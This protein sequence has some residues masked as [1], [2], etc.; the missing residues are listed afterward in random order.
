MGGPS[1]QQGG[2]EESPN[3]GGFVDAVRELSRFTTN[4]PKDASVRELLDEL[5]QEYLGK[6]NGDLA[7]F[8]RY[9]QLQRSLG[10]GTP[11]S[12]FRPATNSPVRENIHLEHAPTPQVSPTRLEVG[13]QPF[14][15][16]EEL[17]R[18]DSRTVMID[19][20]QDLSQRFDEL[21]NLVFKLHS[22]AGGDLSRPNNTSVSS[23]TR[24]TGQDRYS[25]FDVKEGPGTRLIEDEKLRALL[26]DV[27]KLKERNAE[28]VQMLKEYRQGEEKYKEEINYLQKTLKKE[29]DEHQKLERSHEKLVEKATQIHDYYTQLAKDFKKLDDKLKT[30]L[31]EKAELLKIAAAYQRNGASRY[32]PPQATQPNVGQMMAGVDKE[33]LTRSATALASIYVGHQVADHFL[34]NNGP[35]EPVGAGLVLA[36]C[37]YWILGRKKQR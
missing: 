22:E 2:R 37:V 36:A 15:S 24:S 8:D 1:Q 9:D 30:T 35:Y 7:L 13:R 34:P 21:S 17:A 4:T 32:A 27:K 20:I 26:L 3:S 5:E 25:S 28:L 14:P 12:A 10:V 33:E 23:A 18:G 31:A 19:Q 29:R 6:T 16:R 11:S